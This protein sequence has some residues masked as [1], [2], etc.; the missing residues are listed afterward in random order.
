ML[1]Y[2]GYT[3]H[4]TGVMISKFLIFSLLLVACLE[5]SKGEPSTQ[6]KMMQEYAD[7][8]IQG[9]FIIRIILN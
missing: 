9:L 5:F 8:L 1:S 2:H 4:N 7:A 6:E 3:M